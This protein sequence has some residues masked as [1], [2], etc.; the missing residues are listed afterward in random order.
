MLNTIEALQDYDITGYDPLLLQNTPTC[1]FDLFPKG[2]R[3]AVLRIPSATT[4]EYINKAQVCE[5]FKSYLRALEVDP[6]GKEL[7][8]F[9][10]QDRTNIREHARSCAL[11]ELQKK[12][13]F[14]KVLTVVSMTKDS[15]FYH[16]IGP[17]EEL[18]HAK[19]FIDHLLEHISSE[20]SGYF[21]PPKV[22]KAVFNGFTNKLA[23]AIHK[24]F[25]GSKN[26]LTRH[27][28][29]DFIELFYTLLQL[30]IIEV[31]Q[32]GGVSFSCKDAIDIG[33]PASCELF[34]VLKLLNQ[35][36]LSPA[37]EDFMKVLLYCPS[38]SYRGRLLFPDR[39]SR[40]NGL[41][42]LIEAAIEEQGSKEFHK[43]VVDTIA[44]LY[45]HDILNSV[46][47]I[48]EPLL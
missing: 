48:P 25:F 41:T 11:E 3:V 23:H 10:L 39:F 4:Q 26:V 17:Y 9:N 15:D 32:P 24:L 46:I 28:R 30:K 37:E 12:D 8:V 6:V 45:N 47:T 16:Q 36:P 7:L 19:L 40:M 1:I 43:G 33:M 13:E 44:P 38:I 42:K 22:K 5:E 18:N 20:S 35:R 34:L 29:L 27:S 31:V 14:A 2:K 21:Y